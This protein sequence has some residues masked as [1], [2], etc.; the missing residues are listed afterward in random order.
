MHNNRYAHDWTDARIAELKELWFE[1]FSASECGKKLGVSRNSV[2]GKIHRL[3][4]TDS[5]R[6]R[7]VTSMR[8]PRTAAAQLLK[9]EQ[10]VSNEATRGC[11][12]EISP[13][14]VRFSPMAPFT[15]SLLELKPGQ[16]RWP[17]GDRAPYRFCGAEQVFGSSY[18][19]EHRRLS[20]PGSKLQPVHF[21]VKKWG[22][23]A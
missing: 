20:M 3:G 22:T 14:T 10:E 12:A 8:N 7:R 4:L 11:Q 2:I 21:N 1:G 16:C 9:T 19:E 15:L 23:A 17:E 13:K 18:C 6:K 5:D